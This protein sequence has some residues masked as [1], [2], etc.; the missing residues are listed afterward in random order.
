M[1]NT[2]VAPQPPRTRK[3]LRCTLAAVTENILPDAA[4]SFGALPIA[5]MD[6]LDTCVDALSQ[7]PCPDDDK[8]FTYESSDSEFIELDGYRVRKEI[9]DQLQQYPIRQ[10]RV[11]DKYR[12][13]VGQRTPCPL[14]VVGSS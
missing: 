2:E 8:P 14:V 7:P 1:V 3:N 9:V 4:P 12:Y 10:L 5:P 6:F 11:G 13:L